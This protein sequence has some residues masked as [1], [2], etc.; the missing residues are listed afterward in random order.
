MQLPYLV[1]YAAILIVRQFLKSH[2][3]MVGLIWHTRYNL[4]I[5]EIVILLETSVLL[6]TIVKYEI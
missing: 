1:I 6:K 5:I 3:D 4:I 2:H